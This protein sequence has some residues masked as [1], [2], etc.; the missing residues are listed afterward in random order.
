[1]FITVAFILAIF[2]SIWFTSSHFADRI[3]VQFAGGSTLIIYGIWCSAF[4]VIRLLDPTPYG[5]S[6]AYQV[7]FILLLFISQFSRNRKWDAPLERLIP[8]LPVVVFLLCAW[9]LVATNKYVT[10]TPWGGFDLFLGLM[11]TGLAGGALW[12]GA[13]ARKLQDANKV[14]PS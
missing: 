9:M 5:W 7:S 14:D 12:L 13:R 6:D 10:Q 2:A 1:M 8:G 4:G 3:D 11:Y